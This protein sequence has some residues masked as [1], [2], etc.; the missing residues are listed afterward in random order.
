MDFLDI[1]KVVTLLKC[2]AERFSSE[3]PEHIGCAKLNE[4]VV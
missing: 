4:L 1:P 2:Q 3:H